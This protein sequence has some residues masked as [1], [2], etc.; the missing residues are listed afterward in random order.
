MGKKGGK[1]KVVKYDFEIGISEI[2]PSTRTTKKEET[3]SIKVFKKKFLDEVKK[4]LESKGQFPT[5]HPVFVYVQQYFSSAK[6]YDDRDVDNL[7][8]TILDIFKGD[9]FVD[10]SQVGTLLVSKKIDKSIPQNFAYVAIKEIKNEN[11]IGPLIVAN[12]ERSVQLFNEIRRQ[13]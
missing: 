2:I 8:K 11:D 9:V 6:E 1:R 5:K 13:K 7:A 10:D 12:I 3:E 4:I